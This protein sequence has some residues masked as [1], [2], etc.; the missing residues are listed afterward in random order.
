MKNTKKH[1]LLWFPAFFLAMINLAHATS[2][3]YINLPPASVTLKIEY[4]SSECYYYVVLSNIPVGYHVSNGRYLGWCVDEHH[5]INNGKT[6]SATLYSSYDP[7]NPHPDPDWN[8]VNYILNHKQGSWNDVQAAIWRFVDGGSMPSSDAG[9]AMVNDADING[10]NFIPGPGEKMAVIAWINSDT[11]VPI[12]EVTV[13]LQNI[14]PEYPLGPI[15]GI[16]S[17]F[18]ALGVFRRKHL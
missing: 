12:I 17:F 11:Q 4:P 8:K 9:K 15:L 18:A 5:Y 16:G 3:P 1:V 2:G 6:Y 7:S 14:T 13:P 10:E